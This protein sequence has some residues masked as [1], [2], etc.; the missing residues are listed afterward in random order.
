MTGQDPIKLLLISGYGRSGS[1]FIDKVLGHVP[2][3]FSTGELND[4]WERSFGRDEICECEQA[5]SACPFWQSVVKEGWGGHSK[6]DGDELHQR[7]SSVI[8]PLHAAALCGLWK[9]LPSYQKLNK[10]YQ[11]DLASLYRGLHKAVEGRVI[12]DSSKNPFHGLSL[13]ALPNVDIRVI[14]LI[15]D[16]RAVA[17]SWKKRTKYLPEQGKHFHSRGYARSAIA[18]IISNVFAEC[19]ARRASASTVLRYEDFVARPK[20]ECVRCLTDVGYPDPDVSFIQGSVAQLQAGHMVAGNPSRFQKGEVDIHPHGD[21]RQK[22]TA[23]AARYVTALT[24][25]LLRKYGYSLRVK[26][27]G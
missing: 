10:I 18:W 2:G 3:F 27:D 21:W 22:M 5:F 15:R 9:G 17:Y 7:M 1:T 4:V 24:W 6:I 19:L 16:S 8:H 23:S 26:G 20:A 25:P 11:A 14:H 12:I 13:L